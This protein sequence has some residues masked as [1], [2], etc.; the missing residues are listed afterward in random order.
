MNQNHDNGLFLSFPLH[1]FFL[2]IKCRRGTPAYSAEE[3]KKHLLI[4]ILF[5]EIVVVMAVV[6]LALYLFFFSERERETTLLHTDETACFACMRESVKSVCY[7][8][9]L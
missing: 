4:A 2:I 9:I 8:D 6:F 7:Y 5:V 1:T 3:K